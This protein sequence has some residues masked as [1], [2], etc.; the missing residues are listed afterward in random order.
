PAVVAIHG[1]PRANPFPPDKPRSADESHELLRT[2]LRDWAEH[3]IGYWAVETISTGEVI[4]FG[5]LRRT[6]RDE[7]DEEEVLNLYFRFQPGSWG[8]GYA[9]EMATA[10]VSWAE[11]T[12]PHDPVE[13]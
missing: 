5:G 8:R 6:S 7:G 2:W 12:H 10:A 9:S 13:I 4:G 11:R 3:G 1:D